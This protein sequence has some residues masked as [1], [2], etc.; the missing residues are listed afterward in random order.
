MRKII[1][2]LTGI[3][4]LMVAYSQTDSK[5]VVFQNDAEIMGF[6]IPEYSRFSPSNQDYLE[7]DSIVANYV[8]SHSANQTFDKE[9]ID[10]YSDYSKQIYGLVNTKGDK[11]LLVNCFYGNHKD[12]KNNTVAVRGGGRNYFS[13][14]INLKNNSI[15]DFWVNSP[16]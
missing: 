12:W 14:K 11:I 3:C 6:D 9:I 1:M 10:N 16:K 4:L 15:S 13:I 8:L 2:I 7:V 5:I